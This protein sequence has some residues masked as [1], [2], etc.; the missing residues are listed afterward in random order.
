MPHVSLRK[1]GSIEGG[2]EGLL[3]ALLDVIGS[4]GTLVVML[5][6]DSSVPFD[7]ETTPVDVE[8]MGVFAEVFRKRPGVLV[9]DHA[10]ARY[11]ALGP[12]SRALLEPSPLHDYHGFGSVLERLT[13]AGGVVLR[14]GAD[15]STVT[16]THYA[17][18]R[19]RL[20]DKR[21]VRLRYVRADI[22]EQWIESLDD[23]DGIRDWPQGDYFP[24]IWLDFLAAGHARSG[25]VGNATAELFD[26]E[27]FV[28]FATA[29]LEKN[30][31][32]TVEAIS[33]LR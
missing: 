22:G 20:P 15:V 30:L 2:A 1:V 25:P 4:E 6:A 17:E 26:A 28:R 19:A 5:G 9:S 13:E 10:A 12:A 27:Q 16:L 31:S 8:E 29:W 23:T 18:Y 32:F 33:H 21:R 24:R 3:A 14:L 7:A 11:G